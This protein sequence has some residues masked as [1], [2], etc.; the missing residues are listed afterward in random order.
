MVGELAMI[1]LK[2]LQLWNQNSGELQQKINCL[3]KG[4]MV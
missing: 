2:I 4:K 1:Y 3:N